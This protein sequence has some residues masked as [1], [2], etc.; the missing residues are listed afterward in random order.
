MMSLH[1][2]PQARVPAVRSVAH[3]THVR[4]G[5]GMPYAVPAQ[6]V[7]AG[8]RMVALVADK[9]TPLFAVAAALLAVLAALVLVHVAVRLESLV[10][11]A[12]RVRS[13][14]IVD[15]LVHA[16]IVARFGAKRALRTGERPIGAVRGDVGGNGAVGFEGA[17]ANLRRQRERGGYNGH[18]LGE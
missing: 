9:T 13:H 4:L 7:I 3:G 18:E 8:E 11:V 15:A 10:A 1:V 17:V 16:Q 2:L 12:A 6:R 5:T 14:R